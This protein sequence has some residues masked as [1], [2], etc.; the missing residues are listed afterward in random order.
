[1]TSV[2]RGVTACVEN[3]ERKTLIARL[4]ASDAL[5]LETTIECVRLAQSWWLAV[6][7]PLPKF[8]VHLFRVRSCAG[9]ESKRLAELVVF[10]ASDARA[11]QWQPD[12]LSTFD[13][14][15]VERECALWIAQ[16]E[17]DDESLALNHG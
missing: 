3:D 6:A 1:M 5:G 8:E 17:R 9:N 16:L 2:F 7:T 12:R 13:F 14:H 15:V 11:V 10:D 4:D